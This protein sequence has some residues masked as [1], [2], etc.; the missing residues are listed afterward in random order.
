MLL[1]VGGAALRRGC[2]R[3]YAADGG[4]STQRIDFDLLFA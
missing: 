3:Q 1:H 4:V 2:T